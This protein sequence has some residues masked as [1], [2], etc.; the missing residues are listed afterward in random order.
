M[1]AHRRDPVRPE[2]GATHAGG[3]GAAARAEAA[4]VPEAQLAV[5][6]ARH[7]QVRV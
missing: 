1:E 5:E 6:A 2:R 3:A 7:Q 4:Q